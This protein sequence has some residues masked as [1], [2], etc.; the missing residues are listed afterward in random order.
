MDYKALIRTVED[1]PKPGISFKDI[2]TLLNHPQAFRSAIDEMAAPFL[3]KG[4]E[5]VTGPEARGYIF[6]SAVAYRLGAAFVPIRKPGKL[7]YETRKVTYDLE[8]GQDTLE[9]HVDA[10]KPG[11]KVLVVDDLLATGGTIRAAID[12]VE[13]MGGD[14]AGVSFL[15]ELSFLNG[16]KRL[17]NY[18][19]YSLITY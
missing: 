1:F 15:I 10:I 14:V 4:I 16:R 6:A 2:T 12:L 13:A 11:Q 17:Q 19:L 8:Y 5:V 3:D 18:D 7:P 9:A